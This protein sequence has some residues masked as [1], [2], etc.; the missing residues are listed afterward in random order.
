MH[1]CTCIAIGKPI[2]LLRSSANAGN[3]KLKISRAGSLLLAPFF[4]PSPFRVF[5]CLQVLTSEHARRLKFTLQ[6]FCSMAQIYFLS[7]FFPVREITNNHSNKQ[8][9]QINKQTEKNA[10]FLAGVRY[11]MWKFMG[12]NYLFLEEK[13]IKNPNFVTSNM[14]ANS[15]S[16]W[17]ILL[18]LISNKQWIK[19]RKHSCLMWTNIRLCKTNS[20]ALF[21]C[22]LYSQ[23]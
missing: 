10:K 4:S 17:R 3:S 19:R 9:K 15:P 5:L 23:L 20:E 12:P 2:G 11:W 13:W 21:F 1:H 8:Y 6:R 14:Y 7:T 18:A 16:Q 22:L